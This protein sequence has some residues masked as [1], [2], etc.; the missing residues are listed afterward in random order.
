MKKDTTTRGGRV[1]YSP[2]TPLRAIGGASVQILK[3]DDL[4]MF[5]S[6]NKIK[7]SRKAKKADICWAICRAKDM[8]RE[9]KPGPYRDLMPPEG[10]DDA[11]PGLKTEP[12]GAGG[13]EGWP[14]V[15]ADPDRASKRRRVQDDDADGLVPS[16]PPPSGQ[17]MARL[18][19]SKED[20]NRAIQ[21]RETVE[22][23]STLRREIREEKDRR[24]N[25]WREFVQNVGDEG[26]A[27][28]R[29][30]A[31]RAAMANGE[32]PEG[33]GDVKGSYESL[34]ENVIEQD[35]LVRKMAVQHVALIQ[36]VDRLIAGEAA[37]GGGPSVVV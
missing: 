6:R 35:E 9:G 12:R 33:G 2:V 7:G 10:E 16:L 31:F 34:I 24:A 32:H 13:A 25:L 17:A 18:V 8:W 15:D 3:I 27:T 14:G 22:S 21:L 19:R 26:L 20:A 11:G 5:C 28:T 30:K 4:R 36:A 1:N 23:A 29:I 37:G